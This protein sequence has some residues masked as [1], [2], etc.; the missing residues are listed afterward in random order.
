M[1]CTTSKQKERP[2]GPLERELIRAV[3]A[4]KA[5]DSARPVRTTFYALLLRFGAMK[6]GFMM[7]IHQLRSLSGISGTSQN[8]CNRNQAGDSLS[9]SEPPERTSRGLER[10]SAISRVRGLVDIAQLE[11]RL[12]EL[13]L[14]RSSAAVQTVLQALRREKKT[15]IDADE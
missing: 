4:A 12:D 8:S 2:S 9:Y 11:E 10:T 14:N 5:R 7:L 13:Q 15:E 6:P 1:G 3:L